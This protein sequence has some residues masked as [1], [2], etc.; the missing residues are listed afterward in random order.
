MNNVIIPA[1]SSPPSSSLS[2][3]ESIFGVD[4]CGEEGSSAGG[5]CIIH[6]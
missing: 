2:T 5:T 6:F 3:N 1:H 4:R